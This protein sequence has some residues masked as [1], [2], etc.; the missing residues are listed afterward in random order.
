MR[1]DLPP[2]LAVM[3]PHQWLKNLL[4]FVPLVASHQTDPSILLKSLCAFVAYCLVASSVYVINDVKDVDADRMHPRKRLRPF[5]SGNLQ[6]S[7]APLL[8]AALLIPGAIIALMT[9]ALFLACLGLYVFISTAYSFKLKGQPILDVC[10]LASLYTW[11][12]VAGGLATG[13]QLSV[14]LLAFSIFFFLALAAVKRQAELV[15][16][17]NCGEEQAPGRGYSVN[18]LPIISG[19]AMAAGYVSVLVMALYLNSPHV[20]ALYSYPALLW[21]VC[22]VLLYWLSHVVMMAHRGKMHD[23]PLVFALKDSTSQICLVL[24]GLFFVGGIFL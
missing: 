24:M 6:I 16:R 21:G 10:I 12:I 17:R 2:W 23:D 18:D 8:L 1:P 7:A 15:D 14:W 19:M 22:L 11:R 9:N 20:A 3:R 5:A 4:V 13:I